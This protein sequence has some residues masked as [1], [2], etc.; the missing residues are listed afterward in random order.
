MSAPLKI[1]EE[2]AE[3]A[4]RAAEDIMPPFEHLTYQEAAQTFALVSIA[5]SLLVLA[6]R[7]T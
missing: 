1:A 2:Y 5:Q 3:Y 6:Q 4:S 7:R